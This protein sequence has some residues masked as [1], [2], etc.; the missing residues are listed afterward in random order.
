M[1]D[2]LYNKEARMYVSMQHLYESAG[3]TKKHYF[4]IVSLLLYAGARMA[5]ASIAF[6]MQLCLGMYIFYCNL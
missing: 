2:Y 6:Y 1:G 3:M 4:Y 5:K